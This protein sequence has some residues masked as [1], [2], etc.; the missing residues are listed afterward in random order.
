[1]RGH[2]PALDGVRGLAILLVFIHNAGGPEGPR[3]GRLLDLFDV[4][5]NIGWVGVQLFFVLSGFLI[6]G[7]LLDS[8]GGTG[9]WRAFYMRRV[10]RIFPLYYAALFAEFVIFPLVTGQSTSAAPHAFWYVLYLQNW[11]PAVV[12][13]SE[14]GHLVHFWS[15]AVEEQFYIFWPLAVLL[16][17]RRSVEIFAAALVVLAFAVRASVLTVGASDEWAYQ[18]TFARMDALAFGALG[19]MLVRNESLFA[20]W[21]PRLGKITWAL[22]AVMAVI[23]VASRG[24]P[25]QQPV[26]QTVGYSALALFFIAFILLGVASKGTLLARTLESRALRTLGKYSYAIYVFHVPLIGVLRRALG[27]DFSDGTDLHRMAARTGFTALSLVVIFGA[28][29][30]SYHVFEK[31]FLALKRHFVASSA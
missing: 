8:R 7:I 25:R 5:S 31:H 28:A 1:M 22:T 19:A 6:T 9:V 11:S 3:G 15:L 4:A 18:A 26:A 10:L 21:S 20:R 30:L 17:R 24:F 27:V 12:T 29:W 23:V 14:A 13:R 16:L 2:V